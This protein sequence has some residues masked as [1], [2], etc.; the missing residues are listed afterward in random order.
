MLQ[1]EICIWLEPY[2][3]FL[4]LIIA[5]VGDM[6][7]DLSHDARQSQQAGPSQLWAHS[8]AH[9]VAKL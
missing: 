5:Q 2:F 6:W 7:L 1:K 9:C 8:E 4:I 3:K